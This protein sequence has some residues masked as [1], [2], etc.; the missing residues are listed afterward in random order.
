MSQVTPSRFLSRSPFCWSVSGNASLMPERQMQSV[1]D[2][3]TCTKMPCFEI[4]LEWRRLEHQF[5][6]VALDLWLG[7]SGILNNHSAWRFFWH[8]FLMLDLLSQCVTFPSPTWTCCHFLLGALA[9]PETTRLR[10]GY[11]GRHW[12]LS[13]WKRND[14]SFQLLAITRASWASLKKSCWSHGIY[15][16]HSPTWR[17]HVKYCKM[18]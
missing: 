13:C 1:A 11:E 15:L 8:S 6:E 2:E 10:K 17:L 12:K 18:I 4:H 3:W 7:P 9:F 16:S 5:L 14:R